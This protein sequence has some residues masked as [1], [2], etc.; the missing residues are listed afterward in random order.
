MKFI[1]LIRIL[2]RFNDSCAY[3]VRVKKAQANWGEELP[4]RQ[5]GI[6]LSTSEVLMLLEESIYF[7][8][9]AK[10]LLEH[11]T[12]ESLEALLCFLKQS[13]Y[14]EK[15]LLAASNELKRLNRS[16]LVSEERTNWMPHEARRQWEQDTT[17]TVEEKEPGSTNG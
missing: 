1:P 16:V 14:N 11:T 2:C 4:F 12:Q 8:K 5:Y 7:S 17:P 15:I 3:T 9:R 10:E 6:Y 13:A